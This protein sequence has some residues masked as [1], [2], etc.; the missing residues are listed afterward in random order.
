M[1]L[2]RRLPRSFYERPCLEV[3]P[4]LVGAYLVRR[5]PDGARLVGRLVEVEAYLGDG[6]KKSIFRDVSE[7]ADGGRRGTGGR[8]RKGLGETRR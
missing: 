6:E 3:A 5:L 2:G 8:H 7:H 1:H 4:D